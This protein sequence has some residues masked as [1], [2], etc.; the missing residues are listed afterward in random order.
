MGKPLYEQ[1][2]TR[3]YFEFIFV[4]KSLMRGSLSHPPLFLSLRSFVFCPF[5]FTPA[6]WPVGCNLKNPG[7]AREAQLL[8]TV[9][10]GGV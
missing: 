9:G 6:R 5:F 2:Y 1:F 4:M 3:D 7:V 8:V 10:C